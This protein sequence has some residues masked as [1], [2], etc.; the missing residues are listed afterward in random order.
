MN[1]RQ[2]NK[3]KQTT[4]KLK[5]ICNDVLNLVGFASLIANCVYL[6]ATTLISNLKYCSHMTVE[7]FLFLQ[8]FR[9][10]ILSDTYLLENFKPVRYC[11]W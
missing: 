11:C 4:E 1:V 9:C 7:T 5:S 10:L 8:T 6:L 2:S 3:L